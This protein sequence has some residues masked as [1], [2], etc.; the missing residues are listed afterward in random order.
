VWTASEALRAAA[1]LVRRC[2]RAG[3]RSRGSS[4]ETWPRRASCPT[5]DRVMPAPAANS[6]PGDPSLPNLG[7][8]GG[9]TSQT[10]P[11]ASAC[12]DLTTDD[13]NC[14]SCGAACTVSG[15]ACVAGTC[16][17]P[18]GQVLCGA[19]CII[20]NTPTSCGACGNQ[21]PQGPICASESCEPCAAGLLV[22]NN[23]C[24][25]PESDPSNCGAC[26]AVC[27]SGTCTS[28]SCCAGCT[29]PNFCCGKPLSPGGGLGVAETCAPACNESVG[30]AIMCGGSLPACPAGDYCA[31]SGGNL[32]LLGY[33]NCPY[34][35]SCVPS[36][37]ACSSSSAG[38]TGGPPG[39]TT[40]AGGS[41]S[42]TTCCSGTC[43]V[44][45]R[46]P[47]ICQ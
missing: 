27:T 17:C 16:A 42:S 20:P 15:E 46:G 18:S 39:T 11:G 8:S 4:T 2:K 25:D 44:S 1:H 34:C 6:T 3:A 43:V 35:Q 21:C 14:G 26:G 13:S 41:V 40:G 22:C 7:C 5:R 38:G 10:C 31:S 37:G 30:P 32:G 9:T 45:S 28:G 19:S 24:V 12:V 23:Q 47:G 33:E 36:G 29:S